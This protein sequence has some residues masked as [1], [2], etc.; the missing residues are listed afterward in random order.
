MKIFTNNGKSILKH[1]TTLILI[2]FVLFL[3]S[4]YAQLVVNPTLLTNESIQSDLRSGANQGFEGCGIRH[5]LETDLEQNPE[6]SALRRTALKKLVKEVD[7][8]STFRKLNRLPPEPV[9][10]PVVFHYFYDECA[11]AGSY[12]SGPPEVYENFR[13]ENAIERLNKDFNGLTSSE[14]HTITQNDPKYDSIAIPNPQVLYPQTESLISFRLA[15]RDPYGNPTSGINRVIHS[16]TNSGIADGSTLR[17]IVQWPRNTYLNIYVVE[18]VSASG[19]S[20]VAMYPEN[21]DEDEKR[22]GAAIARWALDPAFDDNNKAPTCTYVNAE[23]KIVEINCEN[24]C[25]D[26]DANNTAIMDC[27]NV[28]EPVYTVNNESYDINV[29]YKRDGYSYILSHEVGHWL[30]LRHLWGAKSD[31]PGRAI[32]GYCEIDDFDFYTDLMGEVEE[33]DLPNTNFNDTPCADYPHGNWNTQPELIYPCSSDFCINGYIDYNLNIMDYTSWGVLFTEGQKAYMETVMNTSLSQR[34]EI[35]GNN[36]NAFP[37]LSYDAN[38]NPQS[39]TNYNDPIAGQSVVFSHGDTFFES[40]LDDGS[41]DNNVAKIEL[42]GGL[43]F[44]NPSNA[45]DFSFSVPNAIPNYVS[46]NGL[47]EG[48]N[49]ELI[50]T[51]PTTAELTISGTASNSSNNYATKFSISNDILSGPNV[52]EDLR[53]KIIKFDF[54]DFKGTIYD[55][56]RYSN[57]LVGPNASKFTAI[58]LDYLGDYIYLYYEDGKFILKDIQLIF[59]EGDKAKVFSEDDGIEGILQ[60]G[61]REIDINDLPGE[62]DFYVGIGI[63][64]CGETSTNNQ[65]AGW[66]KLKYD[67]SC[68]TMSIKA[69]GVYA[70]AGRTNEPTLIYTPSIITQEEDGSFKGFEVELIKSEIGQKFV[71]P[72]DLSNITIGSI[73]KNTNPNETLNNGFIKS[74]LKFEQVIDANGQVIDNKFLI[75]PNASNSTFWNDFNRSFAFELTINEDAFNLGSISGGVNQAQHFI[76]VLKAPQG[77]LEY[78]EV[79]KETAFTTYGNDANIPFKFKEIQPTYDTDNLHIGFVSY[80]DKDPNTNTGKG[81]IYYANAKYRIEGL[82]KPNSNELELLNYGESINLNNFKELSTGSTTYKG[83]LEPNSI[84]MPEEVVNGSL[85]SEK[86]ACFKL[87]YNCQEYYGWVKFLINENGSL[88]NFVVVASNIQDEVL[89]IGQVPTDCLFDI[90]ED[91]TYFNITSILVNN[92]TI[93]TDEPGS[94]LAYTDLK[95]IVIPIDLANTNQSNFAGVSTISDINFGYWYAWIDYNR[96]GF[97][98]SNNELILSTATRN[99]LNVDVVFDDHLNGSYVIR[100]LGSFHFLKNPL[101]G[102]QDFYSGEVKDYTIEFFSACPPNLTITGNLPQVDHK[103]QNFIKLN[104][105]ASLF[106][107]QVSKMQAGYILMEP[108]TTIEYG[109]TF[110]AEAI[111]D[112]SS[113]NLKQAKPVLNKTNFKVF[114]NPFSEQCNIEYKLDLDTEVTLFVSDITGKVI[115]NLNKGEYQYAGSHHTTFNAKGLAQGI[116]YC[117]LIAGDKLETQKM[118]ISK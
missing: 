77:T 23:G 104:S 54:K 42:R 106:S 89:N 103:V 82:C 107:S 41:I 112:C 33:F 51:S 9:M 55:N 32:A 29:Y 70:L 30:G 99:S 111:E 7:S 74:D 48:L 31:H 60:S 72:I 115:A 52:N 46:G 1:K 27:E 86:Y 75:T 38:N 18:V 16:S 96:D 11:P 66:L 63:P 65:L 81:Y 58:Y 97:F 12:E 15:E 36:V 69:F 24:N 4:I 68:N 93:P 85:N 105:N 13:F 109:S 35:K 2:S 22:D 28:A 88:S 50:I 71:S 83:G 57:V 90:D 117:T 3:Q 108:N 20:G 8:I 101:T 53:S 73:V 113:L 39:Y 49:A 118:V 67:E 34:N 87:I 61:E 100:I 19:N 45:D 95:N 40:I 44:N 80:N 5:S 56:A 14:W 102:C 6:L 114:P 92:T 10:I 94:D 98:D 116:Y 59:T 79:F 26:G 62:G 43:T 64:E 25:T 76:T 37:V 21:S 84:Y 91:N 17:K 78:T 110:C 47:P